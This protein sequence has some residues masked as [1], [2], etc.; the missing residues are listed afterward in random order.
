MLA[1]DM[2]IK[3]DTVAPVSSAFNAFSALSLRSIVSTA[4]DAHPKENLQAFYNTGSPSNKDSGN[5][6]CDNLRVERLWLVKGP[7]TAR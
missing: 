3:T 1:V 6:R 5:V 7:L 4:G 2:P